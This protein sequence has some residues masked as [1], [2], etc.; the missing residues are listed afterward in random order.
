V[1]GRAYSAL[2]PSLVCAPLS[3]LLS[4]CAMPV[5]LAHSPV[6][7]GKRVNSLALIATTAV[8][9]DIRRL[10]ENNMPDGAMAYS[11]PAFRNP[12]HSSLC[13]GL[14]NA[15]GGQ[16]GKQ[17]GMSFDKDRVSAAPTAGLIRIP[18]P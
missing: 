14:R 17:D 6:C 4:L 7:G 16:K 1:A 18:A 10:P 15:G 3:W 8:D 2:A 13:A 9:T 11:P 5:R 12:A